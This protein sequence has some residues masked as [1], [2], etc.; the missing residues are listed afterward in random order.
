M[1]ALCSNVKCNEQFTNTQK[2]P[3]FCPACGSEVF[4]KCRHCGTAFATFTAMKKFCEACGEEL[5]PTAA[6]AKAGT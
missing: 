6:A 1:R 5:R 4:A 3:K 2:A